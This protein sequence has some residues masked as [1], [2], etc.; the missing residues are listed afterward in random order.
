VEILSI[1]KEIFGVASNTKTVIESVEDRKKLR[2]GMVNKILA[3]TEFNMKLIL[4]HYLKKGVDEQ[5]VI[6]KLKNTNLSK[7][8]EDGFDF[9]TI[10]KGKVT[11][12]MVKDVKFLK[13][14]VG[15]D[16]EALL[17][18]IRGHIEQVKLLP[19]LYD[20]SKTDKVNVHIRL[21]NLGKRYILFSKF[22]KAK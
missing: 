15:M 11:S 12:T 18:K 16:C 9:T 13:H 14:Y 3:E 10:K 8:L 20:L 22:L 4:D 17:K 1:I 7:A 2:R 21:L 19:E 5:V 6:E